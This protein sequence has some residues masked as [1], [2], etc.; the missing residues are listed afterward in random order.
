LE[1]SRIRK[2][3]LSKT[4]LSLVTLS[5]S[6]HFQFTLCDLISDIAL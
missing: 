6:R 4:Q 5:T 1:H 3:S 2:I